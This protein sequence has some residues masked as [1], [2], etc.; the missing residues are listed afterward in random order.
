VLLGVVECRRNDRPRH[1]QPARRVRHHC[2]FLTVRRMRLPRAPRP[3]QAVSL[4]IVPRA[5]LLQAPPPDD[6]QGPPPPPPPPQVRLR[7]P[8]PPP[9]PAAAANSAPPAAA[10]RAMPRFPH[11]SAR[12]FLPPPLPQPNAQQEEDQQQ[13]E[14]PEE[15]QE[16]EEEKD[17]PLQVGL[18]GGSW[19]GGGQAA[20][21]PG[22][23]WGQQAI[24]LE[25]NRAPATFQLSPPSHPPPPLPLSM[26]PPAPRA[27]HL[28]LRGRPPRPRPPRLR[29]GAAPR[30]GEERALQ[31][32]DLLR[33]PRPLRQAH[34]SKGQQGGRVGIVW[35]VLV[36]GLA[37]WS[38]GGG[39]QPRR[40]ACCPST[41]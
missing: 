34:V 8:A 29:S 31:G 32:G 27:V 33:G 36:R 13:E 2:P 22:K 30:A 25:A 14:E 41:P 40:G 10:P 39:R 17:Q 16:K 11:A 38:A 26:P 20:P 7:V 5:P 21:I 28:R 24:G 6:E 1:G 37:C 4:V 18:W 23:G 15:E 19:W 35:G 3:A 12:P 9:P